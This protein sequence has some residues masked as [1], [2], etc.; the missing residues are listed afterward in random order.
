MALTQITS[1]GIKDGEVKNADMADD[2]IGVAELSATGTASSSTFLRGDNSWQTIST[3]DSTKMPLAGGT[4]TNDVT[5]EA[6]T[7]G[8]DMLWD[9]SRDSLVFKD[10]AYI[11]LGTGTDLQIYHNG[12]DNYI[13]NVSGA[14]KLLMGS[15]Y[16]IQAVANGAVEL[17]HNDIKTF[18][19]NSAGISVLGPEGGDAAIYFYADE[20]DDNA[21]Q[22][23]VVAEHGNDFI[24]G[25]YAAGSWENNI[26]AVGN[27]TVE[28]YYD[29][30]KKLETTTNGV[31]IP[32]NN[33][34][35]DANNGEKI[36][37]KGTDNPYIRWYEQT[38]AKAYVQWDSVGF[39]NLFNEETSKGL[40]IGGSGAEVLDSVKF[41][42]GN[43]QDL[44]LYHDGTDNIIKNN[45][46]VSLKITDTGGDVQF[47]CH[48]NGSTDLYHNGT[49]KLETTTNGVLVDGTLAAKGQVTASAVPPIAIE[50]T[51]DSNDFSISQY[52]DANGVYT[53]I[54]QNT[55]LNAGGSDVILDSG[56]K[57][58]GIMLDGRNN[59]AVYI[60]TGDTNETEE[61]VKVD[62]NG[63]LTIDKQPSFSAI[64]TSTTDR[65]TY[66]VYTVVPYDTTQVDNGNHFDETNKRFV[67][68][69]A[70]KYYFSVSQ[71]HVG[72]IILKMRKNGTSFVGG[73]FRS[74]TDAAWEHASLSAVIELAANDYV[75]VVVA[76]YDTHAGAEHAWNGGATSSAFG[77][78][79]FCGWLIH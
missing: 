47:A 74:N 1:E 8:R 20:G 30:S 65:E 51:V 50:S 13:K 32:A 49:K 75:D 56:H 38:T 24:I 15:E 31:N 71:N 12:T 76:L 11:E 79:Q 58:A 61:R 43:D 63:V 41:T 72:D 62:N 68:P 25:N 7:S 73:E 34:T 4:F 64:I 60:Y 48:N 37:L 42:C 55:Q 52:E 39:L 21:D 29:N 57:S 53:L 10:N 9:K 18:S 2:A 70:G 3:T 16:A 28:L 66:N 14:F 44:Q 45:G 27:G 54:G 22:W 19:T 40:R 35:I 78:D 17:Y 36:S 5:F 23:K 67:A 69:V 77:W 33:L 59:G 26:K 46:T 6:N